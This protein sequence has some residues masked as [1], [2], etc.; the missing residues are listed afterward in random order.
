MEERGTIFEE[1]Q[2]TKLGVA[3]SIGARELYLENITWIN[4]KAL[5]TN[6]NT[7]MI[8]MDET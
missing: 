5:S 1:C 4:N 7:A 3:Y 2:G 6:R 8:V